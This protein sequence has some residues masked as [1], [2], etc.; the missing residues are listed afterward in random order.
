[1]LSLVSNLYILSLYL[2]VVTISIAMRYDVWC[3]R[4]CHRQQIIIDEGK[5][6]T[7]YRQDPYLVKYIH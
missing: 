6:S 5:N 3:T 4:N 7:D 2:Y 1:M